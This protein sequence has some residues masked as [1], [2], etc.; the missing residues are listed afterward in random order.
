MCIRDSFDIHGGGMDLIF[1]HHECEIAQAVASQGEDMVHYWMHNN[2]ITIN[3]QIIGEE[4]T[5]FAMAGDHT[6]FWI[7][8]DYDTQE[9][10]YTESKLSRCV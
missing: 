10:D 1:P 7:P 4:K 6:A 8:G 9:Y 3:G 2:M 5:Q